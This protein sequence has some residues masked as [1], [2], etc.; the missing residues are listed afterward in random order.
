MLALVLIAGSVVFAGNSGITDPTITIT[1][2]T[3]TR[4]LRDV[5]EADIKQ[6][7]TATESLI[8]KADSTAIETGTATNTEVVVFENTYTSAP[9]V[10]IQT[11]NATTNSYA[12][13]VTTTNF[14]ANMVAGSTN[15]YIVITLQ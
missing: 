15:T 8:D 5:C 2:F 14:T 10:L 6:L 3:T 13:S 12:S 7:E 4:N 9:V 11:Q 1:K